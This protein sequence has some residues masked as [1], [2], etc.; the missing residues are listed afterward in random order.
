MARK[1]L[2]MNAA[3]G[4]PLQSQAATNKHMSIVHWKPLSQI[5]YKTVISLRPVANRKL[6][7]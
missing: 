2:A 6:Y 5:K 7:L 4:S 1:R 3:I